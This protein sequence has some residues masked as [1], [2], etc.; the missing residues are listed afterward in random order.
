MSIKLPL[1]GSNKYNILANMM[2]HKEDE[3]ILK[4]ILDNTLKTLMRIAILIVNN[5]DSFRCCKYNEQ[6]EMISITL[7]EYTLTMF[8]VRKLIKL[9]DG[10]NEFVYEYSDDDFPI[11][12]SRLLFGSKSKKA[13]R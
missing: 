2:L 13:I 4:F 11:Q 8:G 6:I 1:I 9:E 3:Y 7:N 12:V 10:D 5:K